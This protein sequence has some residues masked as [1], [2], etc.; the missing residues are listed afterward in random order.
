[1]CG[2]LSTSPKGPYRVASSE[3]PH[4]GS[5]DVPL[6]SAIKSSSNWF[7]Q[8]DPARTVSNQQS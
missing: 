6:S 8:G 7:A 3:S 4:G 1:M 2:T 5:V